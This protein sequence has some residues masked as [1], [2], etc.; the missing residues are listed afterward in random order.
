MSRQRT[1]APSVTP[2]SD[3]DLLKLRDL[4]EVKD[5]GGRGNAERQH[6]HEALA[7]GERFGVAIMSGQERDRFGDTGRAGVLEWRQLHELTT[8]GATRS[9]SISSTRKDL[10]PFASI[11]PCERSNDRRRKPFG[12]GFSVTGLAL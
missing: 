9:V 12:Q 10:R 2:L 3:A 11:G 4:A 8:V 6:R 1:M 7:A 5:Q